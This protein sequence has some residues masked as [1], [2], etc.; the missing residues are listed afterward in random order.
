MHGPRS[1]HSPLL[2]AGV[3]FL[4]VLGM[5]SPA[6]AL[7]MGSSRTVMGVSA[8]NGV[9]CPTASQCFGVGLSSD[10]T[11]GEVVPIA[12]DGTPGVATVAPGTTDLV[13]IACP[14]AS[15]CIAVGNDKVVLL[16]AN[17]APDAVETVSAVG[18]S[19]ELTGIA[20]PTANGCLAVGTVGLGPGPQEVKGIIVPIAADGTI[21]TVHYV[22]QSG[23][24]AAV[25]CP[26]AARCV[27]VGSNLVMPISADGIP[28]T[29]DSW[30]GVD[31]LSGVACTG[32]SC[33]AVGFT[34]GVWQFSAIAVP[35]TAD[36]VRGT[37]DYDRPFDSLSGVACPSTAGCV[38]ASSTG[39]GVVPVTLYGDQGTPALSSQSGPIL[40]GVACTTTTS[41][42]AVGAGQS[43]AGTWSGVVV[44]VGGLPSTGP[45][46]LSPSTGPTPLSCTLAAP[47]RTIVLSESERYRRHH[48]KVRL[49]SLAVKLECNQ[50]ASL[51]VSATVTERRAVKRRGTWRAKT[52]ATHV[53]SASLMA[54]VD[55]VLTVKLPAAALRA[56][57][58]GSR[59]VG[60]IKVKISNGNGH[61]IRTVTLSPLRGVRRR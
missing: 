31:F 35:I 28:G 23:G 42:I 17:G 37:F 52:F 1:R 29:V 44:P 56:L 22:D 25:A 8:V 10:S 54:G 18:D 7:T 41:C 20:C 38:A 5:A 26:S 58:Q 48:K 45:T 3:A 21:G 43:T 11:V 39:Y 51:K 27:A 46:L 16:N 6:S 49:G 32:G 47:S 30:S 24:L 57:K 61:A 13:A 19:G 12:A 2:G 9:A 33:V 14:T 34:R 15:S 53:V 60:T 4:L 55:T 59:E 40:Y 36:G 50:A